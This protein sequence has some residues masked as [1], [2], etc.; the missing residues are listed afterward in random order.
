MTQRE[1]RCRALVRNRYG[2]KNLYHR[3]TFLAY[4]DAYIDPEEL[5]GSDGRVALCW[6]HAYVCERGNLRIAR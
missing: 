1:T 4:L 3:C 6:T 2:N 5:F